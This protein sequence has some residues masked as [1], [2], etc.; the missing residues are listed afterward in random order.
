MQ[1]TVEISMYPLREDYEPSIIEFI[2]HIKTAEDITVKVNP[3][4]THLFGDYDRVMNSLQETI[5]FSFQKYGK[6][7]FA[8]K[9]LHGNL[10]YSLV[11]KNLL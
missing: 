1:V 9:V 7:V 8:M 3:S 10:E 11:G 5:K 2:N 4:A 6:V